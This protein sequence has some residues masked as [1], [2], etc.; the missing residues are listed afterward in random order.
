MVV[1]VVV[2]ATVVGVVFVVSPA[3]ANAG[4]AKTVS[5]NANVGS[6]GNS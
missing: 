5:W 2:A 3:Q 4:G 1:V 6:N